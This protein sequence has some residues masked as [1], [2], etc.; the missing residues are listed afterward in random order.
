MMG[1]VEAAVLAVQ[2]TALDGPA[3]WARVLMHGFDGL[4]LIRTVR[5]G[6]KREIV[7]ICAYGDDAPVILRDLPMSRI[8]FFARQLPDLECEL[9]EWHPRADSDD[10]L[11]RAIVAAWE[12]P[13]DP[14]REWGRPAAVVATSLVPPGSMLAASLGLGV[15]D[16]PAGREPLRRPTGKDTDDFYRRV[17]DAYNEVMTRTRAVAPVLAEEAG[18]PARTIHRWVA[19][20]RRRG[21]LPPGQKGRA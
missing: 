12:A 10:A 1:D 19:E 21:F 8:E 20:A 14:N 2:W 15:H 9:T 17:A 11:D 5:R 4:L 18:V 16:K 6:G 13:D 3:P 7:A